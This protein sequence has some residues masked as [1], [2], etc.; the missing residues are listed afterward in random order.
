MQQAVSQSKRKQLQSEVTCHW[1]ALTPED[2]HRF[3]GKRD[4]LINLLQ[5]RYGFARG[6][7]EREADRFFSDFAD[8]LRNAS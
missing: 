4:I 2:L 7:A 1:S 6:R 3:D 8:K 5:S